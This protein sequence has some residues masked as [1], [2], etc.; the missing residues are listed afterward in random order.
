VDRPLPN[1]K[2]KNGARFRGANAKSFGP[3]QEARCAP[4][5]VPMYSRLTGNSSS[6]CVASSLCGVCNV[7]RCVFLLAK[8]CGLMNVLVGPTTALLSRERP[9]VVLS[10]R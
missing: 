10:T 9:C 4:E 1:S 6:P 3:P 5:F 8:G 7:D 2:F